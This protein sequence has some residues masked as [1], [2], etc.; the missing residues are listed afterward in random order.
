MSVSEIKTLVGLTQVL[1]KSTAISA[2]EMTSS[3]KTSHIGS[4]L[5]VVDI[6]SACLIIKSRIEPKSKV[7]LSKGHAAAAL[8]ACLHH[9]G[10]LGSEALENFCSDGS[11]LYGHVNHFAADWIPL[12]T[13]SLG[14]GLPFSVGIASGK[15]MKKEEGNV[16]VIISDGECNEGTTWES[17][18]IANKLRLDNLKVI[19]DRNQIQSLGRTE[20]VL[21]LEPLKDKWEAFGWTAHVIDGH[22]TE[23]ILLRILEPAAGPVCVIAD[24]VKGHGVQFMEGKLAWH[25]KSLSENELVEA[26]K[27]IESKYAK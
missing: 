10:E 14:H 24:T 2:L 11:S 8:Y 3:A 17:A 21:P 25:Y 19:I 4:C 9:L 20:E 26:K 13:G 6:L 23:Q 16:Y 15:Q 22:D 27:Q 7:L 12:S 18:L 5:S 1:A